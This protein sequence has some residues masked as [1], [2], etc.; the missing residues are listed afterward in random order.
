MGTNLA[1]EKVELTFGTE[2]K[3]DSATVQTVLAHLQE[4]G[5]AYCR[6]LGYVS[7]SVHQLGAKQEQ[8]EQEHCDQVK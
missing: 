1:G 5:E 6:E 2:V 7:A 3:L 4:L 8:A